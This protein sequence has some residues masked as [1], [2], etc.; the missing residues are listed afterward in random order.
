MDMFFQTP[1]R[2]HTTSVRATLPGFCRYHHDAKS[3]REQPVQI[4]GGAGK[5]EILFVHHWQTIG[6]FSVDYLQ[7]GG[8]NVT[9]AVDAEE[10]IQKCKE[11]KLTL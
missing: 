7:Q 6:E 8:Y 3:E 5:L 2:I 11:K 9:P 4:V 1:K 10:A